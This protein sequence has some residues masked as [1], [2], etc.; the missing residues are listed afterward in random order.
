[1]RKIKSFPKSFFVEE[2]YRAKMVKGKKGWVIKGMLFA[3]LLGGGM[4]VTNSTQANAAEWVPNSVQQISNRIQSGQTSLEFEYGDTVWH[5]GKA[6]NIKNPMNLLYDNGFKQGEQY[7]IQVGTIISWDGNHVKVTDPSGKVIGDSIIEDTEKH[8]ATQTIAG[9]ESDTVNNQSSV[10][11]SS[12]QGKEIV[13]GTV[14]DEDKVDPNQTVANQQSDTLKQE[15]P[16]NNNNQTSNTDTDNGQSGN[17]GNNNSDGNVTDNNN[18]DSNSGNGNGTGN[19]DGSNNE[20]GNDVTPPEPNPEPNPEP[21]PEPGEPGEPALE[22]LYA[23]LVAAKARLAELEKQLVQA[24]ADL[25]TGIEGNQNIDALKQA[26]EKAQNDYSVAE[27][28]FNNVKVTY[29]ETQTFY[30]TKAS[31]LKDLEAVRDNARD[32]LDTKVQEEQTMQNALSKVI[33]KIEAAGRDEQADPVDLAKRDELT[34]ALV[35][36]ISEKSRLLDQLVE[37]QNKVFSKAHEVEAVNAEMNKQYVAMNKQEK[38]LNEAL[39]MLNEAK[40]ALENAKEWIH[41]KKVTQ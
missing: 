14:K 19:N 36:I 1:M 23:Q 34:N 12:D 18:D 5:I 15:H 37:A 10:Q 11:S 22:E 2:K 30:T 26:V 13:G 3:T 24:E 32:A 25:Q 8:D 33:A 27:G 29:E 38:G 17:I 7:S 16:Q 35:I 41:L 20:N 28:Q 40:T 21:I 31:E 39:V 9:Q 6:L 4:L